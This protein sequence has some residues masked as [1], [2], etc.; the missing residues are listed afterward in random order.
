MGIKPSDIQNVDDF[1]KV[2]LTTYSHDI[3]PEQVLAIPF[4]DAPFV[5]SSGGTTGTPKPIYLNQKDLDNWM[6]II[7]RLT[8]MYNIG[9]GDTIH[10]SFPRPAIMDTFVRSGARY[11]PMYHTTMFIDSQIRLMERM[12]VTCLFGGAGQFLGIYRRANEMEIDLKQAGLRLVICTG[13][14]WAEGYRKRMEAELGIKFYDY[15]GMM[16]IGPTAAECSEQNGLH[17]WEDLNLVEIIDPDTEKP[18]PPGEPG[19]IIITPLWR[20]SM[21]FLRYHTGDLAMWL[22]DEQCPCGRT[23]PRISR[24]KGRI[25]HIIKVQEARIFPRDVEEVVHTIPGLGTE[26]QVIIDRPGVL[27]VL[28]IRIESCQGVAPSPELKQTLETE[29]T[30]A[31]QVPSEVELIPYGEIAGSGRFKALRIV[32]E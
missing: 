21:P 9:K 3:P 26:F 7:G 32:K 16:E 12:K 28:K 23:F 17:V 18:L 29:L 1:R 15:Y 19:E 31:T 10:V 13:E 24:I 2:P 6:E 20:E 30:K 14:T 4:E 11:L 27:D 25:D 22:D 5:F 8:A